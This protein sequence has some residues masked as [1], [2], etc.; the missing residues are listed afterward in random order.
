MSGHPSSYEPTSRWGK[1]WDERLPIPRMMYNQFVAF[2]TPRNLDI[3][4][5]QFTD[6]AKTTILLG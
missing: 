4:L 5:V 3:P 1:W 6:E 2:P